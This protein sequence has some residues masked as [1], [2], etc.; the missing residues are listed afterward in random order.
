MTSTP[1]LIAYRTR[2]PENLAA[3]EAVGEGIRAYITRSKAILDSAGL[4]GYKVWADDTGWSPRRFAGLDIP[5]GEKPP[6]GWR[7]RKDYAVPDKRTAAGKRIWAALEAAEGDHPGDPRA[8]LIG[9]P[10]DLLSGQGYQTCGLRHIGDALYVTWRGCD[11][12]RSGQSSFTSRS[13]EV[14]PA[15]WERIP[16]SAYY[17]AIE[18]GEGVAV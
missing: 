2:D 18:A 10:R 12:G 1:D 9:M 5:A 17:T 14:D 4:S 8:A 15:R 13:S 3:V 7:M 16:L 11:P 6:P